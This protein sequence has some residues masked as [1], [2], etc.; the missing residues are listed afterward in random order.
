MHSSTVSFLRRGAFVAALVSAPLF[1][2]GQTVPDK[3]PPRVSPG[4]S[5]TTRIPE[6]VD[7]GSPTTSNAMPLGT[8]VPPAASSDRIDSRTRSAAARAAARPD[9]LTRAGAPSLPAP[10]I[11]DDVRRDASRPVVTSTSSTPRAA[12]PTMVTTRSDCV[13][14]SDSQFRS[15]MSRCSSMTDRDAR[16]QC[17]SRAS[18]SRRVGG[19]PVA[20]PGSGFVGSSAAPS[21]SAQ[22]GNGPARVNCI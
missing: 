1:A 17:A 21:T 8:P 15:A 22:L 7:T 13:S 9:P 11:T 19:D 14:A 2:I 18:D 16:A 6:G 12:T 20:L 4:T 3:A 5:E 10:L